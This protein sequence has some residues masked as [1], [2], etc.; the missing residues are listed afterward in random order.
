MK[1]CLVVK[2]L[3]ISTLTA[4]HDQC[5]ENV[6]FESVSFSLNPSESIAIMGPNGAGKSLL[7]LAL[8]GLLDSNMIHLAGEILWQDKNLITLDFDQMQSIR[9]HQIGLIL[10]DSMSCLNPTLSIEIQ[11]KEAI[12][13]NARQENQFYSQKE[14]DKHLDHLLRMVQ[15][16]TTKKFKKS[17][18]H[19]LSGGQKQRVVIA[20]TLALK[21]RV[22]IADEPT[23]S[24]DSENKQ[25][26]LDLLK[27][28]KYEYNFSLIFISH[29]QKAVDY[30]NIPIFDLT[31]QGLIKRQTT[32]IILANSDVQKNKCNSLIST[33]I[34][35]LKNVQVFRDDTKLVKVEEFKI[36]QGEVIGLIGSNASGKTSFA[37][38]CMG[39]LTYEGEMTFF[40]K[41]IKEYK[42]KRDYYKMVQYVFQDSLSTYNPLLSIYDSVIEGKMAFNP[43]ISKS[44]LEKELRKLLNDFDLSFHLLKKYPYELSGGQ[45]QRFSLIKSFLINAQ[46]YFL[47]EPTASLD[48]KNKTILLDFIKKQSQEFLKS[49]VLISHDESFLKMCCNRIYCIENG[50]L[51][52]T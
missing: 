7:S 37:M 16:P 20:Q 49:F 14:I 35:S 5:V 36:Y 22:L 43:K 17:F 51:K 21:P 15:L 19:T 27:K 48:F 10:Q 41:N 23:S 28:I 31:T 50:I 40:K 18:P 32:P 44:S 30:L 6:V 47:D 8:V 33:Q 39:M 9:G 46:L 3:K 25:A 12:L 2:D 38:A 29:D 45:R 1:E 42:N 13:Q 4:L 52:L 24:L 11:I 26:F 34:F